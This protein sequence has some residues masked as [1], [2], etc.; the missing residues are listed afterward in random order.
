MTTTRKSNYTHFEA[1]RALV[2]SLFASEAV[3]ER[4]YTESV[5]SYAHFAHRPFALGFE[6]VRELFFEGKVPELFP[7]MA[8]IEGADE[9]LS[10]KDRGVLEETLVVADETADVDACIELIVAKFAARRS[11]AVMNELGQAAASAVDPNQIDSLLGAAQMRIAE[12]QDGMLS[13]RRHGS[14]PLSDVMLETI[15]DLVA[16][17]ERPEDEQTHVTG[18]S[19]GLRDLDEL[20]TGMHPEELWVLGARPSMGKTSIAVSIVE[21]AAAHEVEKCRKLNARDPSLKARPGVVV[22][23]SLEMGKK[24]LAQR[25]IARMGRISGDRMRKGAFRDGDWDAITHAA[26]K[27][28]DLPIEI[29]DEFNVTTA[30][31]RH[32][33]RRLQ[34]KHG[35]IALIVLDY[36][37]LMGMEGRANSTR[38]DDVSETSRGLKLVTR[39]FKAPALVLSQLNR[40]VEQRANK[41]PMMSDLRESGAIEQDADV[42]ML[43]YRDE[44][45]NP[46][47]PDRG[48]VEIILGKQRNGPVGVVKAAFMNEYASV[49]DLAPGY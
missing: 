1:E 19:T 36:L 14:V 31:M 5:L 9:K 27:A 11:E 35:R 39:E 43:A 18:L 33:L 20:T 24:S 45:Y 44:Y 8:K 16:L 40:G 23:Y 30:F 29:C 7:V 22:A 48:V 3:R 26:E 2:A 17:A 49:Q 41:R 4:V 15:E 21:A 34:R 37:Q 28:A 47:S 10:D 12:I 42:I 38:N 46:D 13:K 32:D 6:A 25:F